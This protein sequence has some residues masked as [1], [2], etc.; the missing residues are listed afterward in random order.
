MLTSPSEK[1]EKTKK[2]KMKKKATS[3]SSFAPLTEV[4]DCLLA[5]A[6]TISEII[7]PGTVCGSAYFVQ[8]CAVNALFL[9][10]GILVY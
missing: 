6:S 3:I 5:I 10:G 4:C 1:R 2:Q 7:L 8:L 9:L